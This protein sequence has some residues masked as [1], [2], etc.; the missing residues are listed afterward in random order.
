MVSGAIMMLGFIAVFAA[1]V[2]RVGGSGEAAGDAAALPPP[3]VPAESSLAIPAEARLVA[4]DLDGTRALLTVEAPDGSAS[5]LLLDLAS[6]R[7]VG[8]YALRPE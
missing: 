4:A 3:G 2:Y 7:I 1:L 8:R 5:L 6:G